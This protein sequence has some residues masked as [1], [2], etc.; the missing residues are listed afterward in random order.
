MSLLMPFFF[1]FSFK[2]KFLCLFFLLFLLLNCDFTIWFYILELFPVFTKHKLGSTTIDQINKTVF[3]AEY[4]AVANIQY[5]GI[6]VCSSTH[7]KDLIMS[8]HYDHLQTKLSGD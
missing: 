1:K 4:L 3:I 8:A 6:F 5:S 2:T 7:N